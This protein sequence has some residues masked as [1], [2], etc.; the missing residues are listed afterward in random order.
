VELEKWEQTLHGCPWR[1]T[2]GA[3][4]CAVK[5][6]RTV[7]NGEREETYRKA[8]R[9][10]LTQRKV[11]PDIPCLRCQPVEPVRGPFGHAQDPCLLPR[12]V[13]HGAPGQPAVTLEED[14]GA[15]KRGRGVQQHAPYSILFASFI[16]NTGSFLKD[17]KGSGK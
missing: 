11:A 14:G 6:A 13:V 9:L 16:V 8:T 4:P 2:K 1:T 10:A 3:A 15:P 5:V 12:M 7:L 17:V